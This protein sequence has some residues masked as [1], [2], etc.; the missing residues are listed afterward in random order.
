M[1]LISDNFYLLTD[2]PYLVMTDRFEHRHLFSAWPRNKNLVHSKSCM[3]S[4]FL[5]RFKVSRKRAFPERHVNMCVVGW[6]RP[7]KSD[8]IIT[9]GGCVGLGTLTCARRVLGPRRRQTDA[10]EIASVY[11]TPFARRRRGREGPPYATSPRYLISPY[12]PIPS[13][14]NPIAGICLDLSSDVA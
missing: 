10:D 4:T 3:V 11:F 9:H 2:S 6:A 14:K 13:P 12:L 1:V 7:R 5:P 8:V